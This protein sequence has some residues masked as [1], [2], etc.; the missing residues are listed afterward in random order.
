MQFTSA[1]PKKHILNRVKNDK[2]IVIKGA[3]KVRRSKQLCDE[4]VFVEVSNE[5][6]PFLKA[7]MPS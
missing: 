5:P 7:S 3:V 4:E 1:A 6:A 2:S